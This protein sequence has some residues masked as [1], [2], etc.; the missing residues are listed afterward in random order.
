MAGG[1]PD[2]P[3]CLQTCLEPARWRQFEAAGPL[4]ATSAG[5]PL[6]LDTSPDRPDAMVRT[7]DA[8]GKGN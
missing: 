6:T 1:T 3:V 7:S 4:P 5:C 8:L 2:P